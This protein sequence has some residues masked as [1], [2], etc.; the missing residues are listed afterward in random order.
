MR[1]ILLAIIG[2]V[3]PFLGCVGEPDYPSSVIL[4]APVGLATPISGSH[5]AYSVVVYPGMSLDFNVT[6][7]AST[8]VAFGMRV[9]ESGASTVTAAAVGLTLAADESAPQ[10]I[11][12]STSATQVFNGYCNDV[13]GT[14]VL[15]FSMITA[16]ETIT[17]TFTIN[18]QS[19]PPEPTVPSITQPGF[20]IGGC[21]Q[22]DYT[23]FDVLDRRVNVLVQY[24]NGTG[25]FRRCTQGPGSNGTGTQGILAISASS[26]SGGEG[27]SFV[28]D[29]WADMPNV[30]VSNAR[31]R[32]TASSIGGAGGTPTTVTMHVRN[33]PAQSGAANI[34]TGRFPRAL[35][36]GDFN[37]DGSPDV[38]SA[39][40][41][42]SAITFGFG[43]SGGTY[44]SSITLPIGAGLGPIDIAAF[45]ANRD[46]EADIVTANENQTMSVLLGSE[47]RPLSGDLQV[48]FVTATEQSHPRV[49]MDPYGNF[50]VVWES[51]GGDSDGF[52]IRAH[53]YWQDGTAR[54][55]EFLV[56]DIEAG[57][58]HNPDIAM[59]AAGNFIVCWDEDLGTLDG[60]AE[61][62]QARR[63]M[64]DGTPVAGQFQVNTTAT[65]S[66]LRP[67]V[68]MEPNGAHVIVW[69]DLSGA[70]DNDNGGIT[71]QL[72]D[73]A[74]VASGSEFGV[75][76][77]VFG[78]QSNAAV[79]MSSPT[80][81][82]VAY[83]SPDSDIGVRARC[84]TSGSAVSGDFLVNQTQAN[85]QTAPG[86]AYDGA[87]LLVAWSSGLQ[88]G[89]STGVYARYV[90]SDG[91]NVTAE[92]LVNVVTTDAQSEPAIATVHAD[93]GG[94]VDH[95]AVWTSFTQDGDQ[96]G[97]YARRINPGFSA[98]GN[99][100]RANSTTAGN[101]HFAAVASNGSRMVVAWTGPDADGEGV[102]VRVARPGASGPSNIPIGNVATSMATGDLDL[103][104]DTDVV[105]V[106]NGI[107]GALSV[108]L[109]TGS[110]S[111]SFNLAATPVASDDLRGVAIGD[112]NR[113]G[114]PDIVV[115][116]ATSNSYRVLLGIAGG[117]GTTFNVTAPVGIG[118]TPAGV[119][120]VDL[121]RDGYLDLIIACPS[122]NSLRLIRNNAGTLQPA[123]VVGTGTNPQ[124]VR[125]GDIDRDGIPDLAVACSGSNVIIHYGTGAF[126]LRTATDSVPA[127][128]PLDVALADID[129]DGDLDF[130]T[131][132]SN[133]D[134]IKVDYNDLPARCAPRLSAFDVVSVNSARDSR[135]G[136]FDGDGRPDLA[137]LRFTGSQVVVL[138]GD[139]AGGFTVAGSASVQAGPTQLRL[140]DVDQDGNLDIVV[141]NPASSNFST[142]LGNGDGTL[143]TVTHHNPA[144]NNPAAIE[145]VD[146]NGD[147][148]PDVLLANTLDDNV[149]LML[150]DGSGGFS[151]AVGSP[152]TVGDGPVALAAGLIDDDANVDIAVCNTN[153]ATV[154]LLLG[155]GVGAFSAGPGVA[156]NT[157]PLRVALGD[158]NNDTIL[159]IALVDAGG[160]SVAFG[161]GAGTF[162]GA[163]N[164]LSAPSLNRMVA[165]DLDGDGRTDVAC[166]DSSTGTIHVLRTSLGSFVTEAY[167]PFSG[168]GFDSIHAADVDGDGLPDLVLS[169]QQQDA[170]VVCPN[171]GD[172]RLHD[173]GSFTESGVSGVKTADFNRDG[174]LDLI[175]ASPAND[176]ITLRLGTGTGTFTSPQ[177]IS[178]ATLVGDAVLS[179]PAD[180]DGDG[181]L[182]LV[183][184]NPGGRVCWS[185]GA[186]TALAAAQQITAF[187]TSNSV[188]AMPYD[189]DRDGLVDVVGIRDHAG[190]TD[191]FFLRNLDGSTFAAPVT[192]S[193]TKNSRLL[194][195]AINSDGE[196]DIV[197]FGTDVSGRFL[198]RRPGGP[199]IFDLLGAGTNISADGIAAAAYDRDQDGRV[200]VVIAGH[201]TS[202]P[203]IDN[204]TELHNTGSDLSLMLGLQ[205]AQ[206]AMAAMVAG[207]FDQDGRVDL[208]TIGEDTDVM[209][210]L[211][212]VSSQNFTISRSW[213]MRAGPAALTVGDFNRDGRPDVAV[214]CPTDGNILILLSR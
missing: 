126:G 35:A 8:G 193:T 213:A 61:S 145:L 157:N 141:L 130:L 97:I 84:S 94:A 210:H 204:M 150:N 7:T 95:I 82:A 116:S 197:V 127:N 122:A 209:P 76:N 170:V 155:N 52:A 146:I 132:S 29:S 211:A 41:S 185:K 147:G 214:A 119:A 179:E 66:Q 63:F 163:T 186:G 59:D 184:G 47:P 153:D 81:F 16:D 110:G 89:D 103:D 143:G 134:E 49:A 154:S 44:N 200:D 158:Y 152:F 175:T 19:T 6:A 13:S 11:P 191:L 120:M 18:I 37:H 111:G 165:I 45:D 137:V 125:T 22:I 14:L 3:L 91:S 101:Q 57:N 180:I 117:A 128:S 140:G 149:T 70:Y 34:G 50:V 75:N 208:L 174:I 83:E 212:F 68:A 190:G 173:A 107:T 99:E 46:G 142:I 98:V 118:T 36:I 43:D 181:L 93:T 203:F 144:G 78:V 151:Q 27:H 156:T 31:I 206:R 195:A 166:S 77:T 39:D 108:M 139:G 109:N 199:A 80:T 54:S 88:D 58:Q 32:I 67:R 205:N 33:L 62:I 60:D 187:G 172:G 138:L 196:P 202:A 72:Y 15:T 30:D 169:A 100:L 201:R 96:G 24:D 121:D 113:D 171:R 65:G 4:E 92:F 148:A 131:A 51:E 188:F 42:D 5:P 178:S 86:V 189:L 207:R 136:D 159:D 102:F 114:I 90:G 123:V 115:T 71:G 10:N 133:A 26:A 38:V 160:L 48:N 194:I 79:S 28:W 129:R 1:H 17:A 85:G 161:T 167:L 12:N 2:A 112:L 64:A 56:N 104:G 177:A 105:V 182:D 162:A 192:S 168:V 124:R 106:G 87:T 73:N 40:N 53:M 20:T 135:F 176:T 164:E 25:T 9:A 55:G 21:V 198:P 69:Y 183:W 74:G 23:V